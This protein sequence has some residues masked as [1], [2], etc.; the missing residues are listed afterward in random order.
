MMEEN[1]NELCMWQMA[2]GNNEY[3]IK[4]NDEK[5]EK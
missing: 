4:R 2:N 5:D 1:A 3:T